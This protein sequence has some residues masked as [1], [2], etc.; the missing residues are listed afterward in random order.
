MPDALYDDPRL[1]VLYDVFDDDRSDLDLYAGI[2]SELGARRVLDLGCGTGTLAL[3]LAAAG[4]EVVG[5]D[6]A[7][8]SLDVARSKPGAERVTW[9]HGDASFLAGVTVDLATMT[10]NAVQAVLGDDWPATLTGVRSAL[11]PGGHVVFESRVPARRAWEGWT[12]EHTRRTR[13][14]PSIGPVETWV[15]LVDVAEPLVSFR[16]TYVFPDGTRL[17][18][19]STLAFRA[20]DQLTADAEAAGYDVVAVRDAPDRPGLEHVLVCRRR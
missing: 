18:S 15:E 19:D 8:A 5:V 10:G 6:P 11:L 3:R 20:L 14:V 12:P 16:H 7:L 13:D 1:A 2:V 17:V 4:L 9:R